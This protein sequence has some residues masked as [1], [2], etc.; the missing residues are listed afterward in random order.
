[1]ST[2]NI[3]VR[4]FKGSVIPVGSVMG[5]VLINS[6]DSDK[7]AK[8]VRATVKGRTPKIK[9]SESTARAI[10]SAKKM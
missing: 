6:E 9:I 3:N 1:M 4:N 8:A 7:V 10:R 2:R 5:K